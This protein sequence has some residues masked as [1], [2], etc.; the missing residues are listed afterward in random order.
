[1]VKR[2]PP[3]T[4]DLDADLK[5][6]QRMFAE[7]MDQPDDEPEP[8]NQYPLKRVKRSG[9]K[10]GK[11]IPPL[12]ILKLKTLEERRVAWNALIEELKAAQAVRDLRRVADAR[13]VKLRNAQGWLK[14]IRDGEEL[15]PDLE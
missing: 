10:K 11:V 12:Y 4:V 5:E 9:R 2:I 1:M 15:I 13:G 7:R 8:D 6:R 3:L 14:R